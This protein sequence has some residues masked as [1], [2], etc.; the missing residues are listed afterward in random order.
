[1][2][3]SAPVAEPLAQR[4]VLWRCNVR[5]WRH[6]LG[7]QTL[8]ATDGGFRTGLRAADVRAY[9]E[10]AGVAADEREHLYALLQECEQEALTV[11]A[12]HWQ[13]DEDERT[14]QRE[15]DRMRD[16]LRNR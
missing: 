6:W 2:P 16:Q 1:M 10:L 12:E 5:P 8:W 9:M 7:V 13:A 3:P 4:F 14:Q 11:W 15:R